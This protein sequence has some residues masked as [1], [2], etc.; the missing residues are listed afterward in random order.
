MERDACWKSILVYVQIQIKVEEGE[1]WLCLLGLA[2][3]NVIWRWCRYRCGSL[4]ANAPA[5]VAEWGREDLADCVR[6]TAPPPASGIASGPGDWK[7]K[8]TG[9]SSAYRMFWKR[10][11]VIKREAH[12]KRMVRAPLLLRRVRCGSRRSSL[13]PHRI[14]TRIQISKLWHVLNPDVFISNLAILTAC[15]LIV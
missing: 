7:G 9:G 11:K 4:S 2:K 13:S 15:I 3:T 5:C 10:I 8:R 14:G 6:K 12:F 1:F